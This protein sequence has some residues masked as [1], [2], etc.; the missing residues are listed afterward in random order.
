MTLGKAAVRVV[1]QKGI[2]DLVGIN[3]YYT[4]LAMEMNAAQYLAPKDSRKL[5]RFPEP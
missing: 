4:L 3:G 5:V 2:V 1:E